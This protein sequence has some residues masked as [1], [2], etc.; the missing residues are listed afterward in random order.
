[1]TPPA[2][3]PNDAKKVL[4]P[5]DV[6]WRERT[7]VL[8]GTGAV[9]LALILVGMQVA[10][11]ATLELLG[12]APITF[13]ALGKF[14]PLWSIGGQSNFGPYELGVGIWVLDTLTVI[15]FVYSFEAFYRI[16][17]A[18]RAL[19]RIHHNMGVLLE[20]YPSM[21]RLSLIGVFFFV[22]F[23]ISGTGALAASFIGMLLNVHRG[24]LIAVVSAGGCVGGLLMAFLA[25]NFASALASLQQA[26]SD[27]TTKYVILGLVVVLV[28]ACVIWLGRAFRRVLAE[29]DTDPLAPR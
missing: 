3:E 10:P 17:A 12:L 27:P 26:Q 19:D 21:K 1:M 9:L 4:H 16:P 11:K 2:S 23:P 22:L 6:T 8:G 13:V 18:Q 29:A 28:A 20:V 24:A 7:A 14:L 25:S 5:F 15:L